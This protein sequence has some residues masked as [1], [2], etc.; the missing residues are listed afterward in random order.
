[1]IKSTQTTFDELKSKATNIKSTNTEY[2]YTY[3]NN[4]FP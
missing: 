4:K 3:T 1:M 2:K